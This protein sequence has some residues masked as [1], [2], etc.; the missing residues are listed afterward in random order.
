ME[1]TYGKSRR[2]GLRAIEF[3]HSLN[4]THTLLVSMDLQWEQNIYDAVLHLVGAVR[5]QP[6]TLAD[7]ALYYDTEASDIAWEIS[8][9]LRGSRAITLTYGFEE[10]MFGVAE[11][12]GSEV[13]C[14]LIDDPNMYPFLYEPFEMAKTF[15]E[16]LT[17]AQDE[18]G[19]LS[20]I[21]IFRK[22]ATLMEKPPIMIQ[23]N[24]RADG[25]I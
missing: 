14:T 21:S 3:L 25:V 17:Y 18:C 4:P 24:L 23:G 13:Q 7:V 8:G 16:Y 15:L 12:R 19:L 2:H 20:N 11:A 22:S 5:S 9:L 1:T 10:R 6:T